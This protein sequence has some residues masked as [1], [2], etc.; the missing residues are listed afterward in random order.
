MKPE[1]LKEM[2]DRCRTLADNADDFTRKR[3]LDLALQY[4][5][6]V[7][8]RSLASKRLSLIS[9]NSQNHTQKQRSGNPG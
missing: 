7:E 8:G 1:D 5:A 3:L 4:E 9:V 6:R 2:A